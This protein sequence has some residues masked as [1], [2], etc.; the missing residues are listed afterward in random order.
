MRDLGAQIKSGTVIP[1]ASVMDRDSHGIYQENITG[2]WYTYPAEKY[3]FVSWDLSME[4]LPTFAQHKSPSHI[5][6]C[7]VYSLIAI[8]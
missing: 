2:W 5:Y 6:I 3:E 8:L 1:Q 7:I 4:Y